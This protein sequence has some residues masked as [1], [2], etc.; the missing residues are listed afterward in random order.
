[1]KQIFVWEIERQDHT[2]LFLIF[3]KNA[4]AVTSLIFLFYTREIFTVLA[5]YNL[6]DI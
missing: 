1:M 3:R 4:V 6:Q 5:F 2:A